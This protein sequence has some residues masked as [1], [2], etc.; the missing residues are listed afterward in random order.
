[1]PRR[2]KNSIIPLITIAIGMIPWNHINISIFAGKILAWVAGATI[3]V[4][5]LAVFRK[6]K[7]A[8]FIFFVTIATT[9]VYSALGIRVEGWPTNLPY[10]MG[11]LSAIYIFNIIFGDPEDKGSSRGSKKENHADERIKISREVKKKV[12]FDGV[13]ISSKDQVKNQDAEINLEYISLDD[14]FASPMVSFQSGSLQAKFD[15]DELSDSQFPRGKI[16]DAS[17]STSEPAFVTVYQHCHEG[18][19]LSKLGNGIGYNSVV[20]YFPESS[21]NTIMALS[22]KSTETFLT[23]IDDVM[24]TGE[25]HV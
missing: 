2:I 7:F 15:L 10:L 21:N 13:T 6:T 16:V 17:S 12:S 24:G 14:Q 25:S 18:T 8:P 19:D 1:M 4:A 20:F 9:F 3:S 22:V 5:L 11:V 23:W